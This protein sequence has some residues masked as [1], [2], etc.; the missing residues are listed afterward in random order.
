[1]PTYI[2]PYNSGSRSVNSLRRSMDIR[3]IRREGSRYRNRQTNKVI[4]WGCGTIDNQQVMQGNI[5]NH[6]H[7]VASVTNKRSFFQLVEEAGKGEYVPDHTTNKDTAIQWIEEGSAVVA[8]IV[9][10]GH[11]GE[12]IVYCEEEHEIPDA[13][14]YTKYVKKREEYRVHVCKGQDGELR[15]F[16]I[17]RKARR[18]DVPDDEVNWKIRNNDNGFI[19]ARNEDHTPDGSVITAALE[20][21][22][23]TGL[24][25]GAVD[26]IYNNHHG[27]SYVLEVNTAPGLQGTTLEQYTL[28]LE[29][30]V[31]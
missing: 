15:V 19:Y 10:Q 26:V 6:P 18:S 30:L 20:I 9:L 24:D 11:S 16:D 29:S 7:Q 21:F 4:N 22:S 23:V 14:L 8:R 12:G 28:M 31:A 27:R 3:K 2:Y 13:P 17:Q 1:M 25:F 5:I